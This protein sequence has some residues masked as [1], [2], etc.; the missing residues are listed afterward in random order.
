MINKLLTPVELFIHYIGLKNFVYLVITLQIIQAS[1]SLLAGL[2]AF[3]NFPS[4]L[5]IC[6]SF[7]T[8]YFFLSCFLIIQSDFQRFTAIFNLDQDSEIDYRDV[9]FKTIL[10]LTTV[11]KLLASYKVLSRD[12]IQFHH[13][14]D[15]VS[16]AAEQVINTAQ[17]VADNAKTQSD[18]TTSSAAAILEMSQALSEVTHQVKDV[19]QASEQAHSISEQGH[20]GIIQLHKSLDTVVKEAKDTQQGIKE[21]EKLAETV[22][23]TSESIQGIADQTNLLALNASIEAARAGEFGRG[24]AVVAEEVRELA[25]R[26]HIS[27]QSIVSNINQVTLQSNKILQSMNTV[28]DHTTDCEEQSDQVDQ[29]L[30]AIK[31]STL[32]VQQKVSIVA[33]SAEQQNIAINEI[34]QNIEVVVQSSLDNA[35]IALQTQTV[36]GHLQQLTH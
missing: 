35:E 17:A 25:K 34:S 29:S 9:N 33:S 19:H 16:Y 27:A 26:A 31:Q 1:F 14:L 20:E 21:L 10:P 30:L 15:E 24:F 5:N 11:N 3:I 32:E 13:R 36:A 23:L 2:Y 12:N 4:S 7:L 8:L 18:A 22:S 28:V 6:I